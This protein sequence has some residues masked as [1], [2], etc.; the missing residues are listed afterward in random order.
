MKKTFWILATLLTMAALTGCKNNEAVLPTHD[1]IMQKL[2]G[3]W[4][5]TA[6]NGNQVMTN[7]RVVLTFKADGIVERSM[8]CKVSDGWNVSNEEVKYSVT[9]I[10][11][12]LAD[13]IYNVTSINGSE[14]VLSSA[15]G[16][17]NRIVYSRVKDNL[18]YPTKIV[19]LWQGVNMTGDE[20][21]GN[22]KHRWRY[23][24]GSSYN[25]GSSGGAGYSYYVRDAEGN[26]VAKPQ[27]VSEYFIHGDWFFTRWSDD[28]GGTNYECWD[29][30]L[31]DDQKMQWSASRANQKGTY[32]MTTL[33]MK[34]VD[35][36]T[37]VMQQLPGTWKMVSLNGKACLTN[38]ETVIT[39]DAEGKNYM[40]V[41]LSIPVLKKWAWAVKEPG[42]YLW[43]ANGILEER[44]TQ[45]T[46]QIMTEGITASTWNRKA[47]YFYGDG[48]ITN[49]VSQVFTKVPDGL[50]YDSKIIGLWEGTEMSGDTTYGDMAH[51]W[52][53]ETPDKEGIG[54]YT[55]YIKNEKGEWVESQN[56]MNEYNVHGN[57][58]ACRW[59]D[60]NGKTNYE[61]WDIY[62]LTDEVMTWGALRA[63]ADGSTYVSTIS[64]KRVKE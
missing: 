24:Q 32:D 20:T 43:S 57:W 2:P 40:S 7:D 52:K 50:A 21:F 46:A 42:T 27:S 31:I 8:V 6:V 60:N 28:Q 9:N 49:T 19:G 5:Q 25:A 33:E 56:T 30:V 16:V 11:L 62:E 26:W 55:Y 51:R 53:Y 12:T 4:K 17:G 38:E 13:S 23:N 18:G 64:M 34:R 35:E 22:S 15:T 37:E 44:N 1:E 10:Q 58:L 61:W 48:S 29:I 63:N 39:Y 59:T 47:T 54:K 36:Q 14:M 41:S 45:Y 3:T